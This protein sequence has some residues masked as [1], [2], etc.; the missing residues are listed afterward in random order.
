MVYKEVLDETQDHHNPTTIATAATHYED[1][2]ET[3]TTNTI[4]TETTDTTTNQE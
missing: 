3:A 4:T 2:T 1:Q